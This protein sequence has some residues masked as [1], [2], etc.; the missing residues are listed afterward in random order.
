MEQE[1]NQKLNFIKKVNTQI[2][3][4]KKDLG[5]VTPNIDNNFFDGLSNSDIC[6]LNIFYRQYCA[7][8]NSLEKVGNKSSNSIVLKS[9]LDDYTKQA[10][11]RLEKIVFE[12]CGIKKETSNNKSRR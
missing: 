6:S 1:R 9:M 11:D 5:I 10:I 12:I 8:L 7:H 2:I 4:K 3:L